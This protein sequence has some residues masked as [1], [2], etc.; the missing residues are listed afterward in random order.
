MIRN[1]QKLKSGDL[2][3][4]KLKNLLESIQAGFFNV[5]KEFFQITSLE[6]PRY[7]QNGSL[8]WTAIRRLWLL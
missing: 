1:L 7:P 5:V 6:V 3:F 4:L 2:G 8:H